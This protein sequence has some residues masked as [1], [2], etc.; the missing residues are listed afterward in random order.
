MK[1]LAGEYKLLRPIPSAE[2]SSNTGISAEDQ[3]P[4]F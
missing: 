3:N 1:N 4:G 2:I